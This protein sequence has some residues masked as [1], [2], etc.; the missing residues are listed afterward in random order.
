MTMTMNMI[1][2][3]PARKGGACIP[4]PPSLNIDP[5]TGTLADGSVERK[6]GSSSSG[7]LG[8]G[9]TADPNEPSQYDDV[10]LLI[11]NR[12]APFNYHS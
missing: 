2:S 12:E 9:A 8:L 10:T 11:E 7:R 3:F 4:P 5:D 1:E 6:P